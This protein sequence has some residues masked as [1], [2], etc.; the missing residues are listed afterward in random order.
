VTT[1]GPSDL[2]AFRRALCKA[3]PRLRRDLP[4][5]NY[6]QPWAVLVSEVMLQQTSTS[7]VI[8]PWTRFLKKF[9]TAESCAR[10]TLAE[11][12]VAWS[13]LGYPRRAKS[14]HEAARII[15]DHFHG[16]VPRDV[17]ELRT[18]PGVGEYTSHAVASFAFGQHV[19]VLDTNVGRVLSRALVNQP[20]RMSTARELAQALLPKSDAATFNQAMLDLGAQFCRATPRCNECPLASSCAWRRDGGPDPAP[21]SAGV[22]RPQAPFAGS[23]RQLRGRVMRAL[24][25]GPRA[26]ARLVRDLAVAPARAEVVLD[27]LVRDG[28]VTKVA[29]SY[30]LSSGDSP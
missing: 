11:V 18:L 27:S 12:L 7:R 6:P 3:A 9:P 2:V 17:D 23:N 21:L 29:R 1:S 14:L 22:S 16:E 15:R 5:L 28:L 8:E 24:H 13:G 25:D 26:K 30:S 19:A 20:L 4:W 10:A